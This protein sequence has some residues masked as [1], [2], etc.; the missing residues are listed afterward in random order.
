MSYRLTEA[1][2]VA[3]GLRRIV[4]E[5]L[6]SAVEGLRAGAGAG[7]VDRDKA[8]HEARKSMKKAR[9]AMR[10]AR[11]DLKGSTRRA[12]ST[13]MRDAG[14]RLSGARDAQVMLD[15]LAGLGHRV[16]PPPP[17]DEAR[18]LQDELRARRDDLA[19]RL[20][21]DTGLLADVAA[22][23]E[24]I[25]ERVP[26]WK[27]RDESIASVVAGSRILYGRGRDAMRVALE[28]S[29]EDEAWHE[30]RKRV[31]DLWYSGRILAPL[32]GPQLDGLVAEADELSDVLGDHNDLAVLLEAADGHAGLQEAIVVRRDALRRVA[33]PIGRRLYAERPKAFAA[34]LQSL[35]AAHEGKRAAAAHWL[36]GDA[37]QEVRELLASKPT[38]DPAG[39]RHIAA[40]LR[41]LGLRT[42]DFES[43]VPRRPGGFA[44]E[45]FELLVARGIVRIGRPPDPATL[46]GL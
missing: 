2:G 38:A 43:E 5:E 33:A 18:A 39:R 16:A 11:T 30:W 44:A 31:K 3:E 35:L 17:G 12:E 13:L 7:A 9:S 8:I 19:Q 24:A 36:S 15:T 29:S 23:L 14:R 45:D 26:G 25:R 28:A 32:G 21:G 4:A 37:A 22:D 6:D 42:S 34:R 27:L 41:S 1:E 40:E 46:G 20:E 10:L